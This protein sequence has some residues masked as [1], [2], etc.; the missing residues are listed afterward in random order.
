MAVVSFFLN[1]ELVGDSVTNSEQHGKLTENKLL[2]S[3]R[4]PFPYLSLHV[5]IH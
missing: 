1:A 3:W 2:V 5:Q 4:K